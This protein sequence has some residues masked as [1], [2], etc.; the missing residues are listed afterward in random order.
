MVNVIDKPE[1]TLDV[2]KA[3]LSN[4]LAFDDMQTDQTLY[5]AINR[6]ANYVKAKPKVELID[7]VKMLSFTYYSDL[8]KQDT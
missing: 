8:A 5:T 7:G 1:F 2:R 3:R 6:I 4:V